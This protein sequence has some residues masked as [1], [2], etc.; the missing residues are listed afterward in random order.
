MGSKVLKNA[1]VTLGGS[2]ISTYVRQVQ[3]PDECDAVDDS[4]MGVTTHSNTPGLFNWTLTIEL[5]ADY[6]DNALDEILW[7]LRG[8]VF[9]WEVI[10]ENTTIGTGNPAYSAYGMLS[11]AQRIGGT[12]GELAMQPITIVPAGGANAALVRDVTP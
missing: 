2:D 7:N 1:K 8:T 12:V 10:P 5:K 3:L 4:T 9:A 11:T 6:V